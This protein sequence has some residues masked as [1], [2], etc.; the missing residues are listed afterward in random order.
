LPH[1][2]VELLVVRDDIG[3]RYDLELGE[4]VG[5]PEFYS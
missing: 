3:R 2:Y 1:Q 5:A 4:I